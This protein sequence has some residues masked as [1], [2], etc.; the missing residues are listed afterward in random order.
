[1]VIDGI[2]LTLKLIA[3]AINFDLRRTFK[4][5]KIIYQKKC[6]AITMA[7]VV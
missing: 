4:N 3:S 6:R 2:F 5:E 7:N 1:M